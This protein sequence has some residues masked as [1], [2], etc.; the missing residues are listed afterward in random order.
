V[1][2]ERCGGDS[3]SYGECVPDGYHGIDLVGYDFDCI[4]DTCA[5][6]C[7]GASFRAAGGLHKECPADGCLPGQQCVTAAAPGGETRSCEIH[8]DASSDCPQAM[9]C[10]LPPIVPD[11]IPNV[12]VEE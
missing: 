12:C 8:C 6:E 10:N 3:F 2:T 11:S 5:T 4:S 1:Q 9:R 7:A